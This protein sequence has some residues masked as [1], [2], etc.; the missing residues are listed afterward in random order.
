MKV[1]SAAGGIVSSI[2]QISLSKLK[3][4]D[5]ATSGVFLLRNKQDHNV[6]FISTFK[7]LIFTHFNVLS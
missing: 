6:I 7:K 3:L 5:F 1:V 2:E 4:G